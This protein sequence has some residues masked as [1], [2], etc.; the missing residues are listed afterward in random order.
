MNPSE[1][2]KPAKISVKL[3]LVAFLIAIFAITVWFA[4]D[5]LGRNG[6]DSISKAD[7]SRHW[8][9]DLDTMRKEAGDA[10]TAHD[11]AQLTQEVGTLEID[12]SGQEALIKNQSQVW[13]GQW[14]DAPVS[15]QTDG[16]TVTLGKDGDPT[17]PLTGRLIHFS[18]HYGR[19][20][21]FFEE[22]SLILVAR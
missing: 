7:I 5:L 4:D 17:P 21:I 19:M 6:M 13:K 1:P 12:L 9:V 10:M 16:I 22:R 15:G 20:Q 2:T 14:M 3:I 8:R 18:K 11:L